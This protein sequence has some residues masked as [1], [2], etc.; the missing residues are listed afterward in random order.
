MV[1]FDNG[2]KPLCSGLVIKEGIQGNGVF[3]VED[4]KA[5]IFLGE[6][7]IWCSKRREWIRTPLGGFL[8]HSEDPNC[9]VNTNIHY[10]HGD[11][12]ELYTVRP[13]IEGEELTIYYTLQE[14]YE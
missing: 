13:I 4:F 12:R 2:Y 5:G 11:Q 7:H 6:T 14:Y 3:A 10:H 9:F 8:N 1:K